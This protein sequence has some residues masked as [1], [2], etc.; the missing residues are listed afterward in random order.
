MTLQQ[1][2][3]IKMTAECG[4]ITRSGRKTLYIPAKPQRSDP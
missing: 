4:N 3:Y 1:L 2:T